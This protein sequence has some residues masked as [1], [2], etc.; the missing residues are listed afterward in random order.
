MSLSSRD[1]VAARYAQWSSGRRAQGVVV[2]TPGLILRVEHAV[3]LAAAGV[4]YARAGLGWPLF[5][6]LFLTPDLS[7]LGYLAGRSFGAFTYNLG[8][9]YVLP[10]ALVGWGLLGGQSL[11]LGLGLIWIAHIGFDRLLGYGLKYTTG[12]GHTHLGL[13]GKMRG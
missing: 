9:S 5:A 7:M 10:A 8:H 3:V 1:T 13:V 12:F 4:A 2:G 11:P 6:A